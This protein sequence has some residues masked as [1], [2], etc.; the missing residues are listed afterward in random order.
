MYISWPVKVL[1]K[2][3]F[4]LFPLQCHS[5]IS[6]QWLIQNSF[7]YLGLFV[8]YLLFCPYQK[9]SW[10]VK[11][12]FGQGPPRHIGGH[13]DP[14]APVL[15]QHAQDNLSPSTAHLHLLEERIEEHRCVGQELQ[16]IANTSGKNLEGSLP[17][18]LSWTSK[19]PLHC[20][21]C[22]IYPS[23]SW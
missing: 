23:P 7:Q 15:P 12:P 4:G 11:R 18:P 5:T 6:W 16:C 22:P 17:C 9:K 14:A 10:R 13:E 3:Q 1:K 2:K 21:W 20:G 19:A 8:I